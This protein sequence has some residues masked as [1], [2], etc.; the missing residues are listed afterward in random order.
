MSLRDDQGPRRRS[1]TTTT[2]TMTTSAHFNSPS[3]SDED[4]ACDVIDDDDDLNTGS[5]VVCTSE[6]GMIQQQY[7]DY[8]VETTT[9]TADDDDDYDDDYVYDGY[10]DDVYTRPERP[11]CVPMIDLS[12]VTDSEEKF[13]SCRNADHVT[14]LCRRRALR[15]PLRHHATELLRRSDHVIQDGG[16]AAEVVAKRRRHRR[17]R[18]ARHRTK[19][20]AYRYA[21][22]VDDRPTPSTPRTPR[23]HVVRRLRLPETEIGAEKVLRTASVQVNDEHVCRCNCDSAT[24]DR[25]SRDVISVSDVIVSNV[26]NASMSQCGI[27]SPE[28]NMAA[29]DVTGSSNVNANAEGCNDDYIS[30]QSSA[31]SEIVRRGGGEAVS[32]AD[33]E[34]S[35]S[36]AERLICA[37][38]CFSCCRLS[39]H[40]LSPQP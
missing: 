27:G 37:L 18:R 1:T 39:F 21:A 5:R 9:T 31:G 25:C 20:C 32:S 10:I 12:W 11:D 23:E 26:C 7:D 3:S 30:P 8:D 6:S 16:R 2:T 13:V 4:T 15:H 19:R 22:C 33:R 36:L 35:S 38:D 40:R 17:R 28:T 29:D 14:P 24:T 34:S